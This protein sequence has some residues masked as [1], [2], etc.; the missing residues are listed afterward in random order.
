MSG[1]T[2]KRTSTRR[3]F[4]HGRSVADAMADLGD[5][6]DPYQRQAASGSGEATDASP[7]ASR[8]EARLL[9]F[10]RQAMA[11][12]FE[13]T[14]DPST[15][16]NG[17]EAAVEALD[18]VERIEDQ[19]TVYRDHSEVMEINRTAAEGPVVVESGLSPRG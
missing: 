1:M 4:L 12:Q 16:P 6:V 15:E 17:A 11:C 7:S 3:D 8:R 5:R 9:Q 18:L 13:I 10:S 2:E 14:L 19:L